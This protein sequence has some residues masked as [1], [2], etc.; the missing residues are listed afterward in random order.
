VKRRDAMR[1]EASNTPDS[2]AV[3][4]RS[5]RRAA[6]PRR[7]PVHVAVHRHENRL[8]YKRLNPAAFRIL[9]A[10]RTGRTLSQAIAAAGPKVKPQQVRAWF[11]AW[12]ALGWFCGRVA[13]AS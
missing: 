4:R 9:E 6:L 3:V 7:S 8:F 11:K 10:L 2:K 12:M 13:P 1:S 5:V